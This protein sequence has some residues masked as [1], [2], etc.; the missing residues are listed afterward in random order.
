MIQYALAAGLSRHGADS[1]M[2][3]VIPTPGVAYLT[4]KLSV[5]AG[6]M[7][8]A[9]H[10]P[11]YDNGIKIFSSEGTKL[12]DQAEQEIE[13]LILN[14]GDLGC[15]GPDQVGQIRSIPLAAELY[16]N[17]I[18]AT[19]SPGLRLDGLK[20]VVDCANGAASPIARELLERFGAEVIAVSTRPTGCN[21][22]EKCGATHPKHLVQEVL[23]NSADFGVALDGDADRCILSDENGKLLDGDQVIGICALEM[24]R[25]GRLRNSCIVATHMSNMG[26]DASLR[27]SGISVIRTSV[28]D[29]YV[30]EKMRE[31]GANLGGEQSGHLI[32]GDCSTT[33]DGLL[34]SLKI[35]ELMKTRN[36]PLSKLRETIR[37]LPQVLQ[38]VRVSARH[39]FE[40]FDDLSRLILET[41]ARL[42]DRGRVLVRYSGTE[43]LARVMVEGE[44]LDEITSL[45]G[46]IVERIQERLGI[47]IPSLV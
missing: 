3:G 36:Q 39:P 47:S 13:S 16:A 44:N 32:F 42:R 28:G 35:L 37:L 24:K 10:N 23:R 29:R 38:N 4:R 22:N 5:D 46:L 27:E 31:T 19:V 18:H 1:V 2:A 41:E 33:G 15:A 8:S 6:V 12:S 40:Q 14:G 11:Y 7:I 45:S 26:L 21:I 25:E 43:P 9:S 17:F 34:A 30:A 20:I